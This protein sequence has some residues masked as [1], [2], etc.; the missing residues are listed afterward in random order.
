MTQSLKARLA[1]HELALGG[2]VMVGHPASAEIMA[3]AGFDWVCVDLEHTA[4]DINTAE[5]LFRAIQQGGST[6]LARLTNN[7]PNLIKRVMDSGA[8]G[9]IVPMIETPEQAQAAVDAVYYPPRGKRGVGLARAQLYGAG[10]QE[11]RNWLENEAVCIMQIEHINAV[12]N[13][14]DILSINGVDGYFLGPYDLSASMGL[15]GQLDHPDVLDAISRT[16]EIAKKLNKPGGI[17]IVEPDHNKL[18][19][20]IDQ[21]FTFIAYS[22]DT[23]IIDTACRAGIKLA[24]GAK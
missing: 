3:R 8:G 18:Q 17:H 23:R 16:R 11:Y 22:I 2:W 10:F 7:D 19:G 14:E 24:K 5:N 12:D 13:L 6:P 15:A 20:A 9:I 1:A 4:T 21:G